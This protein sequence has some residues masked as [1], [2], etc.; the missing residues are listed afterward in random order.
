LYVLYAFV[1]S[2]SCFIYRR[3]KAL[4][5]YFY[6]VM[7]LIR[8]FFS[9]ALLPFCSFS[10]KVMLRLIAGGGIALLL[11][12]MA[13]HFNSYSEYSQAMKVYGKQWSNEQVIYPEKQLY[14]AVLPVPEECN[15]RLTSF[16]DFG[17]SCLF[18]VQQYLSRLHIYTSNTALFVG[19]L[20][21][22]SA[23]I[24]WWSGGFALLQKDK[25]KQLAASLLIYFLAEICTP[26]SRSP[27]GVVQHLGILAIISNRFNTRLLLLYIAGLCLNHDLPLRLP[28]IRGIGEALMLLSILIFIKPTLSVNCKN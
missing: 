12:L 15:N 9:I 20:L 27:Y 26:A 2:L 22:F 28:F 19:L 25:D 4:P 5:L 21:L 3:G 24:I 8:P 14:A 16:P 13:G 1:F 17:N 18:S 10:K 23:G 11:V 6:P 7:A